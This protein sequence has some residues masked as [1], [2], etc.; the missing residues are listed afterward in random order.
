MKEYD[1][2]H[3][4]NR[5]DEGAAKERAKDR[6]AHEAKRDHELDDAEEDE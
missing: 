4:M 6:A 2:W 1:Y 3:Q 5:E